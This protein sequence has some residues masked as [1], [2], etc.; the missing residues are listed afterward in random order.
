M[1]TKRLFF[2]LLICMVMT[3]NLHSQCVNCET[4][5]VTGLNASGIGTS[6]TATGNSS[7]AGGTGSMA[8]GDYSFAFGD[9]ASAQKLNSV[10]F[11]YKSIASGIFGTAM[12]WN[13]TASGEYAVALGLQ[14][15][16]STVS[17][18]TIGR[19]LKATAS[20]AFVIGTGYSGSKLLINNQSS[21]LMIGFN[22]TIP[23]LFIS[24]SA[25]E[26][27][28][29]KIG[30]GNVTNPTAKLHL[31][32]D[33]NEA[34]VLK[35]EH[36]T[37]GVNR[38]SEIK[39]S[40]EHSITASE[41]DNLVFSTAGNKKFIFQHG[42]IFMEDISS[43]II[44]KSPNGQCWRGTVTDGGTLQF[45]EVTC[46]TVVTGMQAE[47]STDERFR[48]YPNPAAHL[49]NIEIPERITHAM[50]VITNLEGRHTSTHPLTGLHTTLDI[51]AL[52][53]GAYVVSILGNGSQLASR[54]VIV[55]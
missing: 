2:V 30:I 27:A 20:Q 17:S 34:A 54:Q 15:E 9:Q 41:A 52:P 13:A 24:S 51:S 1:I 28:T 7:F 39:L 40:D 45:T 3:G 37:T 14:V 55:Q 44:M 47:T 36:R 12:G 32:S 6:P 5:N 53:A 29:G 19:N 10:A 21:S 43:G 31:L 50:A 26:T 23:T 4:P 16:S 8:S 48:I 35:L 11:G 38:Y 33:E 22:S 42:D 18:F 46:P 49:L 25:G